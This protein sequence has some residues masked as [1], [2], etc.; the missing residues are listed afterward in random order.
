MFNDGRL[1]PDKSI[2]PAQFCFITKQE[3]PIYD[4]PHSL[5]QRV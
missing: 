5:R 3:L 2:A 1:F 4:T